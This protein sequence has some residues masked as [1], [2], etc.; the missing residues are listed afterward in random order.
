MSEIEGRLEDLNNYIQNHG[1]IFA[2]L[3]R[4]NHTKKPQDRLREINEELVRLE[5]EL[6]HDIE[7]FHINIST[8]L[9]Y[10]GAF[11]FQKLTMNL[12]DLTM[13]LRRTLNE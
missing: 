9:L 13:S 2:S 8:T 3:S 11:R 6:D 10:I 7:V 12:N 1:D 4:Q 5:K